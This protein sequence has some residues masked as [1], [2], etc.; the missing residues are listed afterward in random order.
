MLE[1]W[2]LLTHESDE[3]SC[4]QGAS[5]GVVRYQSADMLQKALQLA[6]GDGKLQIAGFTAT[7]KKLEGTQLCR[8][9]W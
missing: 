8:G 6:D 3:R 1:A 5:T 7:I 9:T 2:S 4:V